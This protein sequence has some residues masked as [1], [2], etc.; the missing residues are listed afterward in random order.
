MNCRDSLRFALQYPRKCGIII[1]CIASE[2][3]SV[4]C[5]SHTHSIYSFDGHNTPAELCAAAEKAGVRSFVITDHYDIDGILD[6]FYPDYDAP[7]A[8]AAIEEAQ[9][10]YDGRVRV[11]R[12]IELGQAANRPE[13]AKAFLAKNQFDFVICSC[14][15]LKNVPDFSFF[16]CTYMSQPLMENLYH[17]MLDELCLHAAIPGQDTVGHLSYPLRYMAKSGKAIDAAHFEA[18]FRRLFHILRENGM[19]I[20]LNTKALRLKLIPDETELCILRLWR[21]CGGTDVTVGSDSHRASEMGIG[22]ELGTALLRQAGF[23]YV[24]MPGGSVPL[25]E[26]D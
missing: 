4:L 25:A 9:A 17:R 21:D 11:Y 26:L 13:E 5:D 22:L 14:H 24:R 6:G 8:K 2:V 20:E 16:D 1:I 18:D 15:N 10:A 12:G 19:A 23:E 7:A 3:T